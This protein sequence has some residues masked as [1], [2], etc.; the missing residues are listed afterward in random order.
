MGRRLLLVGL[1]NPGPEYADTRHNV[2]F[3]VLGTLARRHG[4]RFSR[5][6]AFRGEWA[7]YRH[8]GV[9]VSLLRPLTFMN[10]SGQAVWPA[11]RR[12]RL[13]PSEVLLIYDDLDLPP[14]RLRLRPDGSAGGHRGVASVI[15]AL[16]TEAVPRLRVG[17]GRPPVGAYAAEYVLSP[18]DG[19][20]L[21]SWRRSVEQAADAAEVVCVEG[22][23]AAMRRFNGEGRAE[24]PAPPDS[25]RS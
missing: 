17:I 24:P 19:P 10:D 3:A 18:L 14:G 23:E 25:E 6:L 13:Q 9:G 5:P 1:G 16:R 21:E 11:L 8:R 20:D 15:A 7:E 2:G 4:V 12:L 22:L